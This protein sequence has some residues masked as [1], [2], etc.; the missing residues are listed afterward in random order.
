[1]SRFEDE[2]YDNN[3]E[4]NKGCQHECLYSL[5][6]F[7]PKPYIDTPYINWPYKFNFLERYNLLLSV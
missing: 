3:I 2:D 7:M 4:N 6:I 5:R 1:M